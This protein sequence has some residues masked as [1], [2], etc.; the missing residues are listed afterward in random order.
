M[1]PGIS[2]IARLRIYA[3]RALICT[4]VVDIAEYIGLAIN[5][6]TVDAA[7]YTETIWL[8]LVFVIAVHHILAYVFLCVLNL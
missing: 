3:V 5:Y 8:P 4:S 1:V 6:K 7:I 2:P